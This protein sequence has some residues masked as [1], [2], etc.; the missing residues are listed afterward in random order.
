[1]AVIDKLQ[2]LKPVW[3]IDIACDAEKDEK[4]EFLDENGLLLHTTPRGVSE[5]D[6]DEDDFTVNIA[7]ALNDDVV[8][9]TF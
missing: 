4:I 1:M 9:G 5:E 7:P 8:Q 2:L 3:K 6:E